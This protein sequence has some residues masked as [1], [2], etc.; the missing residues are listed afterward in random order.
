MLVVRVCIYFSHHGPTGGCGRPVRFAEGVVEHL[1]DDAALGRTSL[2]GA[3][4]EFGRGESG[5]GRWVGAD[6]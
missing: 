2:P 5:Y 4:V 1:Q 3:Y 6:S